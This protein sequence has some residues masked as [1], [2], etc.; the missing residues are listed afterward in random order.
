MSKLR[1]IGYSRNRKKLEDAFK[2]YQNKVHM[3]ESDL[4]QVVTEFA[5]KKLAFSLMDTDENASSYKDHA[6]EVA[7]Y[8]WEKLH[9]FKGDASAFYSW[10]HRI[11]YTK[12]MKAHNQVRKDK[13]KRIPLQIESEE[14]E[15]FLD[16]NPDLYTPARQTYVRALPDFIQGKDRLICDLIRE[17]L[18]Y[19]RIGD[20]L[21]ISEAAVKLRVAKMKKKIEEMNAKSKKA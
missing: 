16:D 18:D 4:F 13:D 12:S 11:C 19:K 3:A 14:D 21:V 10:V 5:E 6:Q 2:L 9:T 17:G 7:I 20:V 1:E 15:G 8:V